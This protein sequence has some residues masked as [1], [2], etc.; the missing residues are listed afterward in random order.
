MDGWMPLLP[1]TPFFHS[2]VTYMHT[3][4]QIHTNTYIHTYSP[5]FPC[6]RLSLTPSSVSPLSQI[7]QDKKACNLLRL[8]RFT[9][10]LSLPRGVVDVPIEAWAHKEPGRSFAFRFLFKHPKARITNN[11]KSHVINFYV[12]PGIVIRCC[13]KFKVIVTRRDVTFHRKRK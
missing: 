12:P 13:Q 1:Q 5:M 7:M 11:G 6:T 8:Y 9:T 10:F 2:P 3:Y 4:I